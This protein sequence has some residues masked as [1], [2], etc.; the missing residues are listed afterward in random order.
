[1]DNFLDSHHH[2]PK[3]GKDQKKNLNRTITPKEVENLPNKK[4]PGP[5]SIG[6]KLHHILKK[7]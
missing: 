5:D 4:S 6:R 3:F 1:M 7:S 2:L